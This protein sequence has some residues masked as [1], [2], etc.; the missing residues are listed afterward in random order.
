MINRNNLFS[1]RNISPRA[2]VLCLDVKEQSF[3][4]FRLLHF[5]ILIQIFVILIDTDDVLD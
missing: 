1:R 5:V 3:G 4:K 2:T